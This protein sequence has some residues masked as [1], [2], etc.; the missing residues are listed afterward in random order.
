MSQ[1]LPYFK[2]F[3]DQW[4]AGNIT[5]ETDQIQSAFI[6]ICC[7]YWAKSCKVKIATLKQRHSEAIERLLES[8]IITDNQGFAKI[9][10]LDEQFLELSSKHTTNS[11][12]GKKGAMKRWGK[13]D[14]QTPT[15]NQEVNS[16]AIAVPNEIDSIKIRKDK[17]RKDI[18]RKKEERDGDEISKKIVIPDIMDVKTFFF[19]NGHEEN[20]DEISDAFFAWN[21]AIN[22]AGLLK[23]SWQDLAK[24]FQLLPNT[25]EVIVSES[26]LPQKKV[27]YT[28]MDDFYDTLQNPTKNKNENP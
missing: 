4:L 12:N 6:N 15:E 8:N 25:K 11:Q 17:I 9:K 7:I 13:N 2:F 16:E 22:W 1:E 18:E 10:F 24:K 5:L 19:E 28:E 21:N 20:Y 23:E 3:P 27:D 14:D 26:A